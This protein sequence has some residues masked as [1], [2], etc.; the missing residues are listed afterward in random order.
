M[1]PS[2]VPVMDAGK[3]S[4]EVK[5]E[6][7]GT[8][9]QTCPNGTVPIRRTSKQDLIKAQILKKAF[10]ERTRRSNLAGHHVNPLHTRNL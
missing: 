5:D 2:S 1:E 3:S 4:Y 8:Q 7:F 9:N 6:D 10:R